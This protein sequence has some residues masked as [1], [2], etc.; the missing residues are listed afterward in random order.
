MD[1][2]PSPPI[3]RTCM[4]S[5]CLLNLSQSG[6]FSM[7]KVNHL[8]WENYLRH[9][10]HATHPADLND[11]IYWN[12]YIYTFYLRNSYKSYIQNVYW[13]CIW[14]LYWFCIQN[15]YQCCIWD[16]CRLELHSECIQILQLDFIRTLQQELMQIFV[17]RFVY[18][19]LEFIW[20][21]HQTFI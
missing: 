10:I 2:P 15:L 7:W 14:N 8:C 12:L 18:F 19:Y 1:P 11:F 3:S 9:H 6:A 17:S 16:L 21:L 5:H 4:H 20:F 13:F